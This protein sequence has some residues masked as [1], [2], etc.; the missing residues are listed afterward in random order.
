MISEEMT[1]E[2]AMLV[3]AVIGSNHDNDC[4][5][6]LREMAFD[7]LKKIPVLPKSLPRYAVDML[8]LKRQECGKEK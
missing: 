5:E 2:E 3:I 7:T 8:K 4:Y 1:A 6:A